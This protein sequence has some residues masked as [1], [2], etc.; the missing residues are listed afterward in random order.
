MDCLLNRLT[1]IERLFPGYHRLPADLVDC[2]DT[3]VLDAGDISLA[4]CE[5]DIMSHIPEAI[6]FTTFVFK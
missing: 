4:V 1:L 5:I 6:D 3:I 2:A